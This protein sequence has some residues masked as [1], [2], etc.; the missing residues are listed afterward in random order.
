MSII[1]N[2]A[3]VLGLA[4]ASAAAFIAQDTVAESCA[5]EKTKR[6]TEVLARLF[7]ATVVFAI[8][9]AVS[10]GT[11]DWLFNVKED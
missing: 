4:T 8:V 10:K 6:S 9:G 5:E 7:T 11:M 2:V 3:D 1:K